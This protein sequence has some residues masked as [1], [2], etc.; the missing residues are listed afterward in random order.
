MVNLKK[1]SFFKIK[2]GKFNK[3]GF[4]NFAK[5]V[6]KDDPEVFD[7]S[8]DIANECENIQEADRCELAFQFMKCFMEGEGVVRV[9]ELY[10]R[11]KNEILNTN[12]RILS[13]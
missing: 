11:R 7:V 8:L 3:P 10:E 1:Y 2:D 4:L 6:V 5:T 12:D 9:G 13:Q